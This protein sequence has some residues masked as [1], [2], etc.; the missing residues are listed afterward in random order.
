[1]PFAGRRIERLQLR[2]ALE[3]AADGRGCAVVLLG[4]PGIGRSRLA[5]ELGEEAGALGFETIA[6]AFAAFGGALLRERLA[7]ALAGRPRR[8]PR[9][10]P[11]CRQS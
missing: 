5:D 9:A 11:P 7:C 10:S 4:N 2:A 1:M 3:D 8:R 6:V